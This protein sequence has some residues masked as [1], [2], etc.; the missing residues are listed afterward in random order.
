MEK[1]MNKPLNIGNNEYFKLKTKPKNDKQ[2]KNIIVVM[3]VKDGEQVDAT[4]NPKDEIEYYASDGHMTCFGHTYFEAIGKIIMYNK[5][6]FNV[7]IEFNSDK[8]PKGHR[9]LLNHETRRRSYCRVNSKP[10]ANPLPT[11]ERQL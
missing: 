8:F 2:A 10:D 6:E 9:Y 7:Q 5:N 3:S 1:N 11:S 4:D